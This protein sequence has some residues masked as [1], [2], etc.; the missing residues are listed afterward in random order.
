MIEGFQNA[1]KIAELRKR[2]FFTFAML[3]IY[4]VGVAIPTPGIDGQASLIFLNKRETPSSDLSI[5][6][7]GEHSN[8]FLYL[9]WALC[10]TLVLQSSCSC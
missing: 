10:P 2:I 6:F 4:R 7:R 1:T 8:G 5:F 3:A 9:R